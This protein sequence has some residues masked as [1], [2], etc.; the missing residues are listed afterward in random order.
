L[1]IYTQAITPA[2]RAAQKG[3]LSLVFSPEENRERYVNRI[4]RGMVVA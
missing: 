2:R 4:L 1:D 3:V